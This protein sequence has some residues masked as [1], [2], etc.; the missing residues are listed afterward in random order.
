MAGW[1]SRP[2]FIT[3]T[4]LDM[5]AE[6]DI[7]R[8]KVFPALE[9]RLKPRRAHLEW[10]DLRVG[11]RDPTS[12]KEGARETEALK[13]CLAEVKRSR[14]FLIGLIGDRYGSTP[15]LEHARAAVAEAAEAGE[16]AIGE[17]L[18]GRS[19][20]ELEI[21]FGVLVSP[22]QRK[23]SLFWLRDPLP[24]ETMTWE[25][26][27]NYSEA[28]AKD[29]DG[30]ARAERL[31]ALKTALANALPGRVI[32]YEAQWN[33]RQVSGLEAWAKEVE[34]RLW[35]ELDAEI[36]P[37]GP[38]PSW[39]E[40]ERLAL[41]DFAE[42]RARDFVG[43]KALREQIIAFVASKPE[44]AQR[45]LV[46]AGD[47]GS[48][49]SALW[50]LLHAQLSKAKS[51]LLLSHAA[52]A[53]PR[54]ASVDQMLR[55]WIDELSG[56]LDVTTAL[57]D[58]AR[59]EEVETAF[60][61]LLGRVALQRRVLILI[62]ALDQFETTNR[63][64]FVT[65]LPKLWPDNARLIATA[66]PG[67]ASEALSRLPGMKALPLPPLDEAEAHAIVTGVCKRYRR[68]FEPE[69]VE[70]LA[71]RC[72]AEG[73]ARGNPLWLTLA[74]E[75][76]NLVDADDFARAASEFAHLEGGKRN[77]ALML[78]L[79]AAMPQ[80]IPGLY[81]QSFDRAAKLYGER[82]V[83]AFLGA[84]AVGRGGWRELDFRGVWKKLT[85]E[86]WDE[87]RFAQLRRA[88]RGQ[89]RTLGAHAQWDFAHRQMREA[90]RAWNEKRKLG[91][92]KAVHTA[93][94]DHLLTLPEDDPLRIS[95]TMLHLME[96]E[97][98]ARRA[99]LYYGDPA[100]GELATSGA[101]DVVARALLSDPSEGRA[102]SLA[103][104]SALLEA[105]DVSDPQLAPLAGA[106]AHKF[107]FD[108]YGRLSD[109]VPLNVRSRLSGRLRSLFGRIVETD[110]SNAEWQRD[111]MFSWNEV[112]KLLVAE[113]N[114]PEALQ[115]F[116]RG[117][118]M[119]E[120]L[121]S[122]DPGSVF[123]QPYLPASFLKIGE[124][125]VAQ[126][127]LPL[128][129]KAFSEANKIS[130][131][132]ASSDPGNTDWQEYLSASFLKIGDI[133][134]AQGQIPEALKACREGLAIAERLARLDP[135][136][137]R[138]QR[139][140]SD[141]LNRIGKVLFT[142]GSLPEA[143]QAFRDGLAIRETLARADFGNARSQ[144]DLSGSLNNFGKV[145][146][147]QNK[148]SE[149]L[150]TFREGQTIVERLARV[151]PSDAG[152]QRDLSTFWNDIGNVLVA[153]DQLSDAEKAFRNGL[154]IAE[155]LARADINNADW[156]RDRSISLERTGDV[157]GARGSLAEALKA[158]RDVLSIRRD[159]A[160]ADPSN[161]QLQRDLAASHQ[162]IGD[163]ALRAGH[164][165]E[166][167]R[168]FEKAL[169]IFI[170]LDQEGRLDPPS[171]RFIAQFKQQLIDLEIQVAG[172]GSSVVRSTSPM[173]PTASL[174]GFGG[175]TSPV[176]LL[177]ANNPAA[178]KSAL[179]AS[180]ASDPAAQNLLAVCH[181]RLGEPQ[182]ALD[183][184]LKLLLPAGQVAPAYDADPNAIVNLATAHLMV[185]D[186]ASCH[187]ALGWVRNPNHAGAIQVKTA[188][189]AYEPE[190]RGLLGR[191]FGGKPS[192][193]PKLHFTPGF[194]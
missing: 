155:R 86:D 119:A 38:A 22:V 188:L 111:L 31:D 182:A 43:R 87:L 67:E 181:L 170:A 40:E 39:Q 139:S 164:L 44:E 152:L 151:D 128:A 115:A 23:R 5:Q 57:E 189:E 81:G 186:A 73:P 110:P 28:Y 75:A 138:W 60:A 125:L 13:V 71:M 94:G 26:A 53:S 167:R 56:A 114:L 108:V 54:A 135:S 55:R 177:R 51:L 109:R 36:P 161:A 149:A 159:L 12:D 150:K 124:V 20:T 7:L 148:L 131:G 129:L 59:D 4:F 193:P 184:L 69:V 136:N 122:A 3:S 58:N 103:K 145:L 8:D 80:D 100:M 29:A 16:T 2:V 130:D 143:L 153:Q 37:P 190:P 47:S 82:N 62:D 102:V 9:E 142:G 85:G 172:S 169:S 171:R 78:S 98:G 104:A 166:A 42:D 10:I 35:A 158:Y 180:A 146:V 74:T 70:A 132:F 113:G 88:F 175:G 183:G 17:K 89:L 27:A 64:R 46:I 117:L 6:R 79:I 41:A 96:G 92:K 99:A 118:S 52:G 95:E 49:K 19:V 83:W 165:F 154:T 50:G 162:R 105:L 141:S 178:A 173:V 63:G 65:W 32:P 15:S 72:V 77:A 14:P 168:E 133:L 18:E 84:I 76:L 91:E 157:L 126:N 21:A 68:E 107:L 174:Q 191:L 179:L 112:G 137:A 116:G 101:S 30:P 25:D 185:G 106:L 144:R 134:V 147:A 48:G 11:V 160:D 33:G 97:G 45:G 24:Y 61:S 90:V 187:K 156:Q 1:I 127:K 66:I 176:S 121:E 123:R 34:E 163:C 93:I 140:R 192:E 194:F 120:R